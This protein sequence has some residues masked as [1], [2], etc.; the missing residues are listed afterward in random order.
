MKTRSLVLVVLIASAALLRLLPHPYHFVPITALA[1]FG[2]LRFGSRR[3]AVLVPLLALLVSDLAREVLWRYGV[4]V[5]WGLYRG[6][7]VVYG[8]TALIALVAR[9]SHGTRSPLA[10]ATTTVSASCLFFLVTNF[11][12]WA[13]GVLYPLTAAGLVEC[14]VAAIPFFGYSMLGDLT[15]AT[16]LFGA[17]ALVEARAPA[18]SAALAKA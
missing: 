8:T 15:Y 11:A 18:V 7:W 14:Y 10:I 13:G 2:G 12:V 16:L 9:L 4:S 1:V 3:D 6:M 17:W 5:Q